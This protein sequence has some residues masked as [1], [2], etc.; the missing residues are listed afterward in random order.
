MKFDAKNIRN[1]IL[2]LLQDKKISFEHL[3]HQETIP[4]K[5]AI[6]LGIKMEETI[7]SL[8]MKGKK[9]QK[10]YLICL[11]GH[12]KVDMKALALVIGEPCECEKI[13]VLKEKYGL[14]IGGVCPFGNLLGIKDIFFDENIKNCTTVIFGCGLPHES[15]QAPLDALILLIHPKF[16]EIALR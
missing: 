2:K 3:T 15:I 1:E 16:A 10:N 4:Q 14:D 6:E 12:Q 13:E 5:I 11:L 8:I 7:K 9:S